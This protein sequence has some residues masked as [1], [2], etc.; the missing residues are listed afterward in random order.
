MGAV[1]KARQVMMDRTVALKLIRPDAKDRDRALQRFQ[2][3]VSAS[4]KLDHPNLLRAHDVVDAGDSIGLVLEYVDGPNLSDL[5]KQ[6]GPLPV[7]VASD[8]V[9]HNRP[10][11][12]VQR[13]QP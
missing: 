5:V 2:R 6:H 4:G 12:P 8:L 13:G 11:T 10:L 9:R 3:E 1:Y 7:P